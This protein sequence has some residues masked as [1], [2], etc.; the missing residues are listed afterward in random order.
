MEKMNLISKEREQ[1]L[2]AMGEMAA[3]LAHEIRNPLGSMEL[4]CS[5]LKKDLSTEPNLLN[6]AEQIHQG[7]RTL[8]NI[9]N[10]SLQFSREINPKVKTISDVNHY[11][12]EI[13]SLVQDKLDTNSVKIELNGCDGFNFQSDPYLLK[14]ALLNI[15]QNAV[16]A[17]AENSNHAGLVKVTCECSPAKT[18]RIIV[19]DNGPGISDENIT[20]IFD[21]FFTTKVGGTGLGLP[22]SHSI[23]KS[24]NGV[25][26]IESLTLQGTKITIDL[27]TPYENTTSKQIDNNKLYQGVENAG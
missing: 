5:L 23:I 8:N 9:I 14:Q 21:P 6:L 27:N 24:L 7:I 26:S 22:V 18:L 13:L 17:A 10:N 11:F 16:E 12:Q 15:I 20:K 2:I 25:L 19:E 3:T 1:R 4:Y